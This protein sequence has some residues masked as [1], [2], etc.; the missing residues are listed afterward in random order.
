MP[1]LQDKN[2]HRARPCP[3]QL[4]KSMCESAGNEGLF[5]SFS[6]E[7]GAFSSLEREQLC[8]LVLNA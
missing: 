6:S 7:K 3:R 8:F 4:N 1:K 2:I 5:A